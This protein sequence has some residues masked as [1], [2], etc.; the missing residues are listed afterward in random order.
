MLNEKKNN[1]NSRGSKSPRG[2]KIKEGK[3]LVLMWNMKITESRI[4]FECYKLWIIENKV[5]W[6]SSI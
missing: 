3:K 1:I 4:S 5:K 2:V 6:V